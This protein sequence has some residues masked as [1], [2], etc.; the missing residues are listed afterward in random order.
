MSKTT[1]ESSECECCSDKH[2]IPNM[3]SDFYRF[4]DIDCCGT[5]SICD[6]DSIECFVKC[7][8]IL[9]EA[10]RISRSSE[11]FDT[12]F[13]VYSSFLECESTVQGRLPA[14]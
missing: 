8:S 12:V 3:F 13:L 1:S 2:R 11:D 14:E 4:F 6:T 5:A 9:C 10:Y 7:F